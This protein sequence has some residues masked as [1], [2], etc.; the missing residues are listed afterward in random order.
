MAFQA[1]APPA[2]RMPVITDAGINDFGIRLLTKRTMHVPNNSVK[3][4]KNI[5]FRGFAHVGPPGIA[6]NRKNACSPPPLRHRMHPGFGG[7]TGDHAGAATG[8]GTG[9]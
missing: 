1:F 8:I 4:A 9:T 7:H 5:P 6:P 2:D 3:H